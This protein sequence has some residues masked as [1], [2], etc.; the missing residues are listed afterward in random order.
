ME[1]TKQLKEMSVEMTRIDGDFHFEA[2]GADKV[3]VHIDGAANIGGT[4]QGARPMELILMGLGGCSAIDVVLILNKARQQVDDIRIVVT[5]A[6]DAEATPAPFESV[7]VKYFLKGTLK[8]DKVE[9]AIR[10]S[11][12]KYCSV[13]AMLEK[14]AVI[15]WSYEIEA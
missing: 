7:H 14:S 10:L 11:M 4:H 13:T 3:S 6:R 1:N 15:T 9:Q 12:E 5:G 8:P 2:V